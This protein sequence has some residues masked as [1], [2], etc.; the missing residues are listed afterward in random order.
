MVGRS[1]LSLRTRGKVV[2]GCNLSTHYPH[3]PYQR[4]RALTLPSGLLTAGS[5]ASSQKESS[6][7]LMLAEVQYRRSASCLKETTSERGDAME[8]SSLAAKSISSRFIVC[9]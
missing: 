4:L 9:L 1:P 6:R 7:R 2:C 5:S 8:R 3:K